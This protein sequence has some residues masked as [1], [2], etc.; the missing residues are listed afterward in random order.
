MKSTRQIPK[1]SL[2]VGG[3]SAKGRKLETPDVFIRPMMGKVYYDS[4]D[5]DS[6]H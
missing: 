1:S 6:R 2:Y 3:G 4:Y 5:I